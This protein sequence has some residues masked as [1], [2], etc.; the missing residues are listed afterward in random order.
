M[1]E[2]HQELPPIGSVWRHKGTGLV[3]KVANVVGRKIT[4]TPNP[5]EEVEFSPGRWAAW[6]EGAERVDRPPPP[7][8]LE[9]A[10]FIVEVLLLPAKDSF[11]LDG[12][13]YREQNKI[14][15]RYRELQSQTPASAVHEFQ[16]RAE[17]LRDFINGRLA[18]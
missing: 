14:S 7:L 12:E 4:V 10:E 18:K 15:D 17:W 6:R 1:P 11:A 9:E 5:H 8:T 2:Q 16:A 3:L 13:E